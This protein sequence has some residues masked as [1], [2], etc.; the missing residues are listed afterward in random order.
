MRYARCGYPCVRLYDIYIRY[1][2]YT[3]LYILYYI[4]YS[5][6]ILYIYTQI[7]RDSTLSP[8]FY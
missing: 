1:Y 5:I 7:Y 3:I 8:Q 2:I 4:L 6:Y